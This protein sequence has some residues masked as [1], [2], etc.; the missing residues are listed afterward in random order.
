MALQ[1]YTDEAS[2]KCDNHPTEHHP[3]RA[4]F[5]DWTTE[6][7]AALFN[8]LPCCSALL[9]FYSSLGETKFFFIV[10]LQQW[11]KSLKVW[12][13]SQSFSPPTQTQNYQ[14]TIWNAAS[15]LKDRNPQCFCFSHNYS[16]LLKFIYLYKCVS[17]KD[18]KICNSANSVKVRHV[19]S[20]GDVDDRWLILILPTCKAVEIP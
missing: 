17:V 10:N 8:L 13:L 2:T 9:F 3:K 16:L 11:H 4:Q 12:N 6:T 18:K 1:F 20:D 19:Q 14:S 15:S 5:Q 7:R